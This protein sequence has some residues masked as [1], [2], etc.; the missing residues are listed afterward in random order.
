[1]SRAVLI[2]SNE[3]T[4]I[5]WAT[6]AASMKWRAIG[7]E[8]GFTDNQLTSIVHEPGRTGEDDYFSSVLG[9]W[10]DWAPPNHPS[11]SIQ[12][13]SA[14]LRAVGK[15]NQA[16]N[17]ELKYGIAVGKEEQVNNLELKYCMCTYL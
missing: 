2:N 17:L 14:A 7:M 1:M 12:Q 10:L 5:F 8:L 15:E 13:L 4:E 6:K 11:P 16:K 9:K 3:H